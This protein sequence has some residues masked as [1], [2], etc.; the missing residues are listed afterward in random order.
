MR[1]AHR[2]IP[3]R[4]ADWGLQACRV[5][6][7]VGTV[8]EEM[9]WLNQVGTFGIASAAYW[10]G[11]AA[12]GIVRLGHYVGGSDLPVDHLLY[13]DDGWLHARSSYA[14]S[15]LLLQLLLYV[16]L[17]VPIAWHK[18]RGGIE[19]DF[20]GYWVDVARFRVGLSERRAAWLVKWLRDQA[21]ARAIGSREFR[22]GLGRLG[23]AA[24]PLVGLRPY[25]GP[26]YAW[27]AVVP[28]GARRELPAMLLLVLEWLAQMIESRRMVCCR[29]LL[30]TRRGELF[31]VDAKAEGNVIALGGWSLEAGP[32]PSS[33]R[34]FSLRLS[35][36]TAPW[37]F[38]KESF[39]YIASFELLATLIALMVF[40]E[41]AGPAGLSRGIVGFS[42]GTDNQGNAW[43]IERFMTTRYPLCTVLMEMSAQLQHRS[44]QLE[45]GWLPRE[46]NQPA[47]D[48]TNEDFS[49]FDPARRVEVS[50]EG[51]PFLVLP[52]LLARGREYM[53]S[54]RQARE[55]RRAADA[56]GPPPSKTARRGGGLRE[57]EPW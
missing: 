52:G 44:V 8:G 49:R 51:L 21:A 47:D 20:V 55:D 30:P 53:E 1:K 32:S 28:P 39:R 38:E 16:I 26:L 22:E 24:G 33:A 40:V 13:A 48:L 11:R 56:N 34:W 23:F 3:V 31:R 14:H 5:D 54:L 2:A 12:A 50:W 41:P 27:A 9:V 7:D 36:T 4:E 18:V 10:W 43:L 15:A 6:G 45:L 17:G 42:A 29:S 57:R 35:P 25:L 46:A 37:A 19:R